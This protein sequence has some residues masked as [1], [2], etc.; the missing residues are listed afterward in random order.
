MS[1]TVKA[2]TILDTKELE[3]IRVF[4]RH[5]ENWVG[6]DSSLQD[7][8][9][10]LIYLPDAYLKSAGLFL[11][12][13]NGEVAGCVGLKKFSDTICELKRLYVSPPHR[14]KGVGRELVISVIEMAQNQGYKKI[15]LD[16]LPNMRIALKIY[17]EMGFEESP[18]YYQTPLEGTQFMTLDLE[19]WSEKKVNK[20]N[21]LHLFDFNEAWAKQM[22]QMDS[23]YFEKLSHIQS[24]EYLWIGCSDSRVPANQIVGLLPGEVFVHR[25][26]ANVVVHSDLNCMSVIQ[27]A[28][29]ILKVKHIMVV[30]HYGCGGIA[31]ALHHKRLGLSDLWIRHVQDIHM[32]HI[33]L[34]ESLEPYE[35]QDVLCE[36]NVLE[37]A[38]HVCQSI[39]IQDAWRRGQDVTIH[40]WIYGLK[41]GRVRDLGMTIRN[42]NDVNDI[43]L[44]ALERLGKTH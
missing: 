11:A 32:K 40:G 1:V 9:Q 33:T 39:V 5:Y 43:Y 10:E 7:F 41:D 17:R 42:E 24:P 8:D 4:L 34:I 31:A 44:A 6:L 20:N 26:I 35:K 27:F 36:V 37:Q 15:L 38:V 29:D 3:Q 19:H 18:A 16:T 28:V 23:S 13:H 21:L 14:G 30:G 25:N 22:T 2:L 12:Y